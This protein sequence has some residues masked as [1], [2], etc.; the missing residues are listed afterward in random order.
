M[1]SLLAGRDVHEG[2]NA[3]QIHAKAIS[4]RALPLASVAPLVPEGVAAVIDRA[5]RFDP[6]ER[7]ASAK[8]MREALR[9]AGSATETRDAPS[10]R[11][12]AAPTDR[13]HLSAT[14]ETDASPAPASA[15]RR[16]DAVRRRPPWWALAVLTPSA[17]VL[18]AAAIHF[19][20]APA[21]NAHPASVATHAVEP[22]ASLESHELALPSSVHSGPDR[23]EVLPAPVPEASGTSADVSSAA[24]APSAPHAPVPTSRPPSAFAGRRPT[25]PAV[26][27]SPP[28]PAPPPPAPPVS[29]SNP[30]KPD[31]DRRK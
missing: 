1:F 17:I 23:T 12:G 16:P 31:L 26:P 3:Y 2:D 7:F 27:L 10:S 25:S 19:A 6:T 8:E 5:L 20:R 9:D 30:S 18:S 21:K 14:M 15:V 4:E 22:T 24:S 11:T 29:T 13:V 28:P